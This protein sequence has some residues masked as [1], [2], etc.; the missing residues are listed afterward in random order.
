MAATAATI[1]NLM[2]ST[3]IIT[4]KVAIIIFIINFNFDYDFDFILFE[5][6]P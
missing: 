5:L 2:K 3:I 1:I 4:S 6:D